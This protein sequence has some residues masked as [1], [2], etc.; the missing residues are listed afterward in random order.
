MNNI[1][2][3]I[4]SYQKSNLIEH[5]D[6][7][8]KKMDDKYSYTIK[9]VDQNNTNRSDMFI[10]SINKSII[11]EYVTWDSIESPI[12]KKQDFIKQA[13]PGYILYL[14]DGIIP[15]KNFYKNCI[16]FIEEEVCIISGYGKINFIK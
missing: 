7:L 10:S 4:Y 14:S 13:L 1:S 8:L 2:I 16:N 6:E 5:I 12:V 3:F 9:I 15:S 11:Y